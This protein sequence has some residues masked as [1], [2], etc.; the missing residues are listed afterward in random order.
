MKMAFQAFDA[1]P[2]KNLA[3]IVNEAARRGHIVTMHISGTRGELDILAANPDV[4][5]TAVSSFKGDV[6]EIPV[7][8]RA[9]ERDIPWVVFCDSHET[10]RR[11]PVREH[12]PTIAAAIV[13]HPDEVPLATG[14]G[15][16]ARRV[17]R[18]PAALEEIPAGV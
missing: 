3:I 5:V 17:P 10:W 9:V 2:G 15:V 18:L 12:A 13:A 8:L 6:E 14:W 11:P 16:S 4:L 1:G 7:G